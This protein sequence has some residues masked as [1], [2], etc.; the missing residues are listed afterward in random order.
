MTVKKNL[1]MKFLITNISTKNTSVQSRSSSIILTT[2][3]A[4]S[5]LA[6]SLNGIGIVAGGPLVGVA[7]V[8]SLISTAFSIGSE[9]LNRK[10][11]KHEKNISLAE[12]KHLLISRLISK[13][14]NDGSISDEEFELILRE[15]EQYY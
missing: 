3:L 1:R 7:G 6:V 4:S 5:S 13:A 10:I 15:F 8:L 9:R 12:L 2:V 14:L 11:S